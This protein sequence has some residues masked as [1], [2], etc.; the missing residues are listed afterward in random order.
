MRP[1][2]ALIADDEEAPR[3]QLKA[4]LTQ[5]WPEL[6]LVAEAVNGVDAWDAFLEHE[7]ALCFLDIRMPGLSGIEVAQRIQGRADVVFVT[8]YGD[9]ALQAFEAGAVDYVMKPVDPARLAQTVARLKQRLQPAQPA[10]AA[11][12]MTA[13]LAQL[14][15]QLLPTRRPA[16]MIQAS[17]GKEVRLIP[18]EQV[19]Y[20]ESDARY[21]RV[22]YQDEAGPGEALIR[23]PL[24]ELLAQLDEQQF[25]QVHRS[26]IVNHRHI[27]S[28]LR[29][30]EG[31]ML[32]SLRGR[33]EKLPVS[34]H[35]QGLFKGQ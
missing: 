31:T 26:V 20:F 14:S 9:H 27:A 22:V 10:A 35:F 34:R 8:A 28:A 21:T 17:V 33:G 3:G 15:Q 19:V 6:E 7:P 29:V 23:T 32:L 2:T 24:K 12:D 1:I 4:A 16:P 30:D 25:W 11:P 18:V 5:A 13:L